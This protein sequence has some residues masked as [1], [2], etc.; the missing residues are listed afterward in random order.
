M[1]VN[2][3]SSDQSSKLVSNPPS[4]LMMTSKVLVQGPGGKQVVARAL[5]DSGSSMTLVSAKLA[6]SA[7][8]SKQSQT[9]SFSGA[10]GTPLKQSQSVTQL[11][12]CPLQGNHPQCTTT[13]AIVQEVTCDLPLQGASIVREMPHLN[14]LTPRFIPMGGLIC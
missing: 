14:W 4:C 9:V 3:V 13:A 8:L 6:H 5:L 12:I 11:H 1:N 10:Q 7:Q 2:V